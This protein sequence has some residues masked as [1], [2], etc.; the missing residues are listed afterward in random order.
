MSYKA[1]WSK[2][3][4]SEN[5]LNTKIVYADKK[6]GTRLSKE[7]KDLLEKY[8]LLKKRCMTADGKIFRSIF[9]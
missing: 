1:I 4:Y 7:G 3:K 5:H 8:G 9:K 6:D 2:I